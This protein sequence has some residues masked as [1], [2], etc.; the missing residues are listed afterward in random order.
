MIVVLQRVTRAQVAAA[1]E[2][3]AAIGP[4]VCLLCCAVGSDGEEE[5]SWLAGK[6]A[7]LRIFPAHPA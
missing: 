5:A 7:G 2:T 1:G 4:G 6:V 3:V